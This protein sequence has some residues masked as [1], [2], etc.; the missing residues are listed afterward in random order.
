MDFPFW[1]DRKDSIGLGMNLGSQK[2]IKI[3]AECK[4]VSILCAEVSKDSFVIF[5]L[6]EESNATYVLDKLDQTL[7]DLRS[8]N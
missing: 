5:I 8:S 7:E 3:I 4:E 1:S 2:I 6:N